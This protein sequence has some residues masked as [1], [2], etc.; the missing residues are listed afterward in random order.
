MLVVSR[1]TTRGKKEIG[2]H[3]LFLS[4][5]QPRSPVTFATRDSGRGGFFLKSLEEC[6]FQRF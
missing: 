1:E 6:F 2:A 3:T 4:V 5:T